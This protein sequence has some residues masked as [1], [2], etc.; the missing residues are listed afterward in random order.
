VGL[1]EAFDLPIL[2]LLD[3][4]ILAGWTCLL[5][6]FAQKAIWVSTHYRPALL[7]F[8]PMD[9]VVVAGMCLIF[10][11]ALAA[12][13]WVKLNEPR[14]QRLERRLA[15]E[16]E[17]DMIAEEEGYSAARGPHRVAPLRPGPETVSADHR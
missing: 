10:A 11:V 13:T 4:M 15:H 16:R 3:L 12:R 17:S 5:V 2:P 9:F 14:L 8:T 1:A 7:G 6:G